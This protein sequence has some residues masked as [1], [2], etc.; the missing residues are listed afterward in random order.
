MQDNLAWALT[1][2]EIDSCCELAPMNDDE[3][4][5]F[6]EYETEVGPAY[7]YGG[8][9][10]LLEV[11]KRGDVREFERLLKEYRMMLNKAAS[12]L[13]AAN[14]D[15]YVKV[16]LY[17][18]A[19]DRILINSIEMTYKD[20]SIKP[21]L[22]LELCAQKEC[23]TETEVEAFVKSASKLTGSKR[24]KALI[25]QSGLDEITQHKIVINAATSISS[26]LKQT[27]TAS[28]HLPKRL[29]KEASGG[30]SKAERTKGQVQAEKLKGMKQ[31]EVAEA[32]Q[33]GLSTVKRCWN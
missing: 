21:R 16:D 14:D 11:A 29:S 5:A 26:V 15:E 9:C 30:P 10:D 22:T 12:E 32:L 19:A 7:R 25:E 23:L 4:L 13:K 18:K 33:L 31:R 28:G 2:E 6:R 3:L 17:S 24:F 8:H 20:V 27:R 1:D